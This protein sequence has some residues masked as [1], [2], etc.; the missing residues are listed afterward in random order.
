MEFSSYGASNYHL[1][2]GAR[3]AIECRGRM[4]GW[5]ERTDERRDEEL[6]GWMDGE[7]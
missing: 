5:L 4:D 3:P 1:V 6:D 7:S 2:G